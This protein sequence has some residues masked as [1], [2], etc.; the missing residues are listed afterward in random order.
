MGMDWSIVIGLAVGLGLPGLGALA[1][2]VRMENRVT[3]LEMASA[4]DLVWRAAVTTKLDSLA[5]DLNQLIGA[6]ES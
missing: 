5:R 6:R 3:Q 4:A 2:L 1:F